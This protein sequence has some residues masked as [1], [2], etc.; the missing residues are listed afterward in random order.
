M[1]KSR[2]WFWLGLLV[3]PVA[4]LF[5]GLPGLWM[6]MKVTAR[7]LHPSAKEVPS[8]AEATPASS[9]GGVER[10]RQAVR[11][12]L[13]EQN[14]PGL[15]VAV[16]RGG[17]LVWSEGFGYADL[18]QKAPV[19]PGHRFRLGTASTVLTSA[20]AGLLME[21]GLLKGDDEIQRY[22]PEFPR[23]QW[24]VTVRALMGHMA[25]IRNDAGDEGELYA[26]S[27]DRPVEGLRAFADSPLLFEPGTDYRFSSYGW[28][29]VSAA[30]EAAG[31]E[32]F[33][34]FMR[35]Q[36]FSPLGMRDTVA[37]TP[38]GEAMA[39][40]VTFYFPRFAADPKYGLHLMRDLDYSCYSGASVFVTTAADL[41]RFGLGMESGKLL[42]GETVRMLQTPQRLRSGKETGYGLGWDVGS[43]TLA[44]RPARVA[45]HDG[46][47]LGGMAASLLTVSE[48]GVVV[49]VLSNMSYADTSSLAVKVAE[50]FA[51]P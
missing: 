26:L 50:A 16:G 3:V 44:G 36:V 1:A 37:E 32:A 23:K 5:V 43:V 20:A 6:Y 7:P 39:N 28:I 41:V 14:L 49:A 24:P 48:R 12:H 4:L 31:G 21:R 30:V 46:T 42:K 10:A 27:C 22:V 29:L 8:V 47:M 13:A 35:K 51:A 40:R 25:G 11:A 15:S 17:Q 34:A 19:T 38:P 9:A 33:L 45:G 18:D 2:G